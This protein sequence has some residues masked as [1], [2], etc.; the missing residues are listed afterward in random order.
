MAI[1][2]V[3]NMGLALDIQSLGHA[4]RALLTAMGEVNILKE[5]LQV[6]GLIM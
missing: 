4:R 6:P 3:R 5:I 2:L 1:S